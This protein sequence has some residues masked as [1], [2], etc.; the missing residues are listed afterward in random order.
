MAATAVA[1]SE[2]WVK[3]QHERREQHIDFDVETWYEWLRPIT[4]HTSFVPLPLTSAEA[5]VA[6]YQH[7]Y[8][9][10]PAPSPGQ[11]AA[12]LAFEG[13][14][15]REMAL[16]RRRDSH[17]EGGSGSG[18]GG[19]GAGGDYFVRLSTRS[20]KDAVRVRPEDYHRALAAV[21]ADE[22]YGGDP[23]AG[24]DAAAAAAT[25]RRMVAFS[26][27]MSALAVSSGIQAMR[28]LTASERVFC[29]L[30]TATASAELYA[31][32]PI[33]VSPKAGVYKGIACHHEI[34]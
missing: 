20:P 14:I 28:L 15:D 19:D 9:S 33:Q 22:A 4:F 8:N 3:W 30:L 25:N 5:L 12:L 32:H 18:A 2:E 17:A 6:L 10:R 23:R 1:T 11:L 27:C 16:G 29:D 26:D 13:K 34:H 21:D 7:R 31:A 24:P